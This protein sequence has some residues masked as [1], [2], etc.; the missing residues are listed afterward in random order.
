VCSS[1]LDP[2]SGYKWFFNSSQ[3]GQ[4]SNPAAGTLGNTGRNGFEQPWLWDTDMALLKRFRITERHRIEIR[5][6]AYNL[7][8]SVSFGYP[9]TSVASSTFGRIKDDTVSGSRKIQMG[10]KYY[11]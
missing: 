2:S 1:D 11:F 7:T 4:F 10:L 6:D 3:I 9:T 8:N 5:A